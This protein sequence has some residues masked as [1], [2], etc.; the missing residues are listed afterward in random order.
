M[1]AGSSCVRSLA[2]TD[3]APVV[4]CDLDGVVWRGDEPIAPAAVGIAALRAAGLRVGFVSNNSSQPVAEVADK[5]TR[6]GVPAEPA[7]VLTSALAAAALLAR[8]LAPGAR[9]LACAGPGVV[10]ALE[11]VGLEPVTDGEAD[12]V[13]VGFHR[14]FDFDEL[15]RASCAIRAGAMFVATNL[16]AT[17]PMPGGAMLPGTGAITAAVAVASG[18]QPEV[19]GKPE[20]PTVALVRERFGTLWGGGRRPTVVGRRAGRRA[21]MAVRPGVVGR[22]RQGGTAR[23]GSHPI[24]AAP[25]RRRGS[26]CARTRADRR[27]DLSQPSLVQRGPRVAGGRQESARHVS[28]GGDRPATPRCRAG[29]SWAPREPGASG[30]CDQ[31]G[32]RAGGREPGRGAGSTRRPRRVDPADRRGTPLRVAWRGEARRRAQRVRG[33]RPRSPRARCRRLDRRLHR[34]PAPG[35]CRRGGGGR[36]GTGQLAWALRN[37]PRVVVLERTNVRSLEPDAIGGAVDLAVAD[38]SFISLLTVARRLTTLTSDDAELVV[39]VKP[40]FE[41]GRARIGKGGVVRDPDVH[42]ARCC[43]RFVTVS[44]PTGWRRPV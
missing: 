18:H 26:G 4:C 10:E 37:D 7:D 3:Q 15:D 29:A 16:D 30:R 31:C 12:A 44:P 36:R 40:Q 25:V 27:V 20:P 43:A 9:V 2:M 1:T 32:P 14:T 19:A 33:A 42:G 11:G 8:R 5:L 6:F 41:A 28:C 13:V 22:H 34:L 35:G 39:L 21:R 23:R 24:P 17:Y 38:L